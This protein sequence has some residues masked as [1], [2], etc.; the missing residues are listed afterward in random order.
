MQ[1]VNKE[2]DS[3]PEKLEEVLCTSAEQGIRHYENNIYLV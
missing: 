1:K 3:K 2:I